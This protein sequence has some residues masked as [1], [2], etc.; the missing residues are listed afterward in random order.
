MA[1]WAGVEG[2]GP[3]GN[4]SARRILTGSTIGVSAGCTNTV[5]IPGALSGGVGRA[6]LFSRAGTASRTGRTL[7]VPEVGTAGASAQICSTGDGVRACSS[8]RGRI[9]SAIDARG[10]CSLGASHILPRSAASRSVILAGYARS[11]R[12]RILV[13]NGV[14]RSKAGTIQVGR[15][16]AVCHAVAHSLTRAAC[17]TLGAH[18]VL[19]D[20]V[21][22]ALGRDILASIAGF[23][24]DASGVA[25]GCSGLANSTGLVLGFGVA[26]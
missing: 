5:G 1:T 24:I 12:R 13:P 9:G 10:V 7:I 25:V 11:R 3:G 17:G 18:C 19:P 20:A 21:A 16:I 4:V 6:R 22:A 2:V 15:R 8:A 23:A 26:A 14:G